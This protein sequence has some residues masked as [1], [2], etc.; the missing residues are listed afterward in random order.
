M[1]Y[2]LL[3]DIILSTHSVHIIFNQGYS[4]WSYISF[5][6]MLPITSYTLLI[7]FYIV[8]IAVSYTHLDVYKRQ[9][10][11][12][13]WQLWT[14]RRD[15]FIITFNL[16]VFL[17]SVHFFINIITP[18]VRYN[19]KPCPCKFWLLPCANYGSYNRIS[20]GVWTCLLYTSRCV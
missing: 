19:I 9:V 2:Y 6:V 13:F 20:H 1:V 8:F 12:C 11:N 7:I 10:G 17:W 18:I 14:G 3:T 16:R 4:S 5:K 15:G